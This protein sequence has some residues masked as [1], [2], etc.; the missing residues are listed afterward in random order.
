VLALLGLV[1]PSRS[2]TSAS[3]SPTVKILNLYPYSSEATANKLSRVF[4]YP[5]TRFINGILEIDLSG[6]PEQRKV[7]VF[8]TVSDDKK[9][10]KKRKENY[11]L[12]E[13]TYRLDFTELLDLKSIFGRRRLKLYAEVNLSGAPIVTREEFFEVEGRQLPK[14]A[15]EDFFLFPQNYQ[16]QDYFFP[17]DLFTAN[18][19]FKVDGLAERER[20]R[21]RVVGTVDDERAFV[22][23]PDAKYFRYDSLWEEG[24]GPRRDGR[25]ILIFSGYFP[26]YFYDFGQYEHP[27][28]IHV[29]FMLDDE[30]IDRARAHGEITVRDP[31]ID[32]QTDDEALRTIQ[33]SR[34]TRWRLRQINE[35]YEIQR[36][37]EF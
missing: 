28:T 34:N 9:V 26:R 33:I 19:Y 10:L 13:G 7:S 6:F 27:F 16:Y 31:G 20:L 5:D 1:S 17:G 4:K 2:Q 25:Y 15:V 14:I 22:V 35:E 11:K 3:P 24:S 29:L 21:I 23:D 8:L 12:S 30:I 18:L 32:Y 36:V 37:P